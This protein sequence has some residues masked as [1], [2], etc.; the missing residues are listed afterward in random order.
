MKTTAIINIGT[1]IS[2][3]I[4]HPVLPIAS[5]LIV[6]GQITSFNPSSS[7]IGGADDVIDVAGMTLIPGLFDSHVHPV[8]GGYSPRLGVYDW[9]ENYLQGGITSMVS[10]GELHLPGRSRFSVAGDE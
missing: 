8:F 3:E 10:L 9:I 4:V 7:A 5:L 2:G 1:L 6:D